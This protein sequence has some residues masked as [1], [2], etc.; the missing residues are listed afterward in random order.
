MSSM[1][2]GEIPRGGKPEV[3]VTMLALRR[4]ADNPDQR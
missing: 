2:P 4:A 3:G 1:R